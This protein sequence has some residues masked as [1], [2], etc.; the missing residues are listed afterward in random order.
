[1]DTQIIYNVK[2]DWGI[3]DNI[4]NSGYCKDFAEDVADKI[5]EQTDFD[6]SIVQTKDIWN[7][8]DFNIDMSVHYWVV[9]DGVH[10]DA[11]NPEG[12]QEPEHLP[13]FRSYTNTLNI[14]NK[15]NYLRV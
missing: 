5:T 14:D 2:Q 4:I 1:M 10:Y 9:C 13:F 11:E 6:V 3:P 8:D 12:V 15:S 7:T